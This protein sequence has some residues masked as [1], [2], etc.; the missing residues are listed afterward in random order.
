L[1]KLSKRVRAHYEKPAAKTA[2]RS[3]V[4][5]KAQATKK[6][7]ASKVTPTKKANNGNSKTRTRRP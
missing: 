1:L 4:P 7:A 5:K 6:A 3:A 2:P